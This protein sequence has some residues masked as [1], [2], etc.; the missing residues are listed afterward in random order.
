MFKKDPC[1][2]GLPTFPNAQRHLHLR[3]ELSR[4]VVPQKGGHLGPTQ[5]NLRHLRGRPLGHKQKL[6]KDQTHRHPRDP[7]ER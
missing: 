4:I 3:R 1:P 6:S 7:P 5:S 2:F